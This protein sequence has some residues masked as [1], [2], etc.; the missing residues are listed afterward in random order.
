[1]QKV[2]LW[3][4]RISTLAE[5]LAPWPAPAE[6]PATLSEVYLGLCPS[7]WYNPTGDFQ[8]GDEIYCEL[9]V[10]IIRLGLMQASAQRSGLDGFYD[11]KLS[12]DVTKS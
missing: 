4:E 11:L 1:M 6:P 3:S 2:R 7:I 9:I 10:W 12:Q 8:R 5:V